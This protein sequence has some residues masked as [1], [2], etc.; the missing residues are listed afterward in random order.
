MDAIRRGDWRQGS[1]SLQNP[2]KKFFLETAAE[3]VRLVNLERDKN[4]INWAK[5]SMILCGLDIGP[6]GYWKVEQLGRDLGDI[7]TEFEEDFNKGY[8]DA[9]QSAQI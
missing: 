8:D 2:G 6:C 5:K 9:K 3:C 4:G 7:V 1:G